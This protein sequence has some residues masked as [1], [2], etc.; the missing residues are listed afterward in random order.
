MTG[1][2]AAQRKNS[3]RQWGR[4]FGR[5]PREICPAI[6]THPQLGRGLH[7]HVEVAGRWCSAQSV[8]LGRLSSHSRVTTDR[9]S[10]TWSTQALGREARSKNQQHSRIRLGSWNVG[11]LCGRGVEVCEELRKRKVDVYGLQKVRWKN[12]GTRFLVFFG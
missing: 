5:A 10:A 9:Q 3:P 12:E 7:H 4:P 6:S 2:R 11:S 8:S 1:Q